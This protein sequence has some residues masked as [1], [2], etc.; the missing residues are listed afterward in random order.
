[1]SINCVVVVVLRFYLFVHEG[2]G[3]AGETRADGE[4]GSMQGTG[5]GTRSQVSRITPLAKGSAKPL[6]HQGCPV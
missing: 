2:R 6:G 5:H 4:V 1:M 3:G